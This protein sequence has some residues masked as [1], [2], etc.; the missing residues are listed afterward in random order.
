MISTLKK[1][2]EAIEASRVAPDFT[3]NETPGLLQIAGSMS[4]SA[5]SAWQSVFDDECSWL[6]LECIDEIQ[7][8]IVPK[9]GTEGEKHRI[10]LTFASPAST[11]HI[12]TPEGWRIFLHDDTSMSIAGT[13]R[14]AFLEQP[15]ST[16]AFHVEPW[17]DIPAE[18]ENQKKKC[19]S[20]HS[21]RKQ[22]RCQT[23]ELMA[24]TKIEYWILDN[25]IEVQ[26][27]NDKA[28]IIWQNIA[29]QM[30]S[31]S[32]PNELYKDGGDEKIVLSGQPPRRLD[33]GTFQDQDYSFH[34]LQEAAVWVYLEGDDVEVRHTFLSTELARE[35][36]PNK[37]FCPE[38][39][40]RLVGALDS[41]RLVYKAHLRSGSKD[42][43]KA[44]TDLRKTLADEVQKLLQQSRDLS[45]TVWRD[46]AIA[47][48]VMAIRFTMESAKLNG[49]ST[50]FAATF[51][52]VALYISISYIITISTNNRFI[53]IVEISRKSWRTKLYAFLDDNDYNTLAET[54]L[55]EAIK[56]YRKTQIQTNIVI[57]SVI[58]GLII[59][60]LIEVQWLEWQQLT[61]FL[62]NIW[63]T[64]LSKYAL[65]EQW[66]I[67]HY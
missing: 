14:L 39:A 34:H 30:I 27:C 52:I 57:L 12:F 40:T 53:E 33:F 3:V 2:L 65:F 21:P 58:L 67:I 31:K 18:A 9:N 15:F 62:K 28:F 48:G 44:L 45:T 29:A 49:T 19:K 55:N 8:R 16:K 43:L 22:V 38:L 7:D 59:G 35:W 20:E 6:S 4:H 63:S 17:T 54:P 13:V 64:I 5:L 61:T 47:I 26:N 23:S 46:V 41:A 56:A 42:T 32:L 50:G 51:F 1:L 24:P 36:A 11:P 25:S 10:S 60:I 37:A 66:L